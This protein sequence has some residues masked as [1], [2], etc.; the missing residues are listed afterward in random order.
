MATG[1]RTMRQRSYYKARA[2][3]VI[4][5]TRSGNLAETGQKFIL[6]AVLAP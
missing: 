6:E 3:S 5:R 2:T 1:G 4:A